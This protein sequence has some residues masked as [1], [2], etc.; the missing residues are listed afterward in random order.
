MSIQ[1]LFIA[2][3]QIQ[4]GAYEKL[5]HQLVYSDSKEEAEEKALLAQCHCGIGEGAEWE[6]D[7]IYDLSGEFAY[8]LFSIKEISPEHAFIVEQYLDVD[9]DVVPD[10]TPPINVVIKQNQ[11]NGKFDVA[12]ST[13]KPVN[14]L[15]VEEDKCG[16][17]NMKID[18]VSHIGWKVQTQVNESF[19]NDAFT[20]LQGE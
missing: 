12:Y 8:S 4:A 18:D 3:V 9:P 16:E 7:V 6:G 20:S 15:Y 5:K 2:I 10:V 17:A 19:T 1:K 11:D 13:V 14:V